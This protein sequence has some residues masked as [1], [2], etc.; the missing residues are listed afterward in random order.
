MALDITG[1]Q[2]RTYAEILN[3]QIANAKNLFGEDIDTSDLTPLGKFIRINTYDLALAEEEME[4]LYYAIFPMTATGISLDRLCVFVG[5]TRNASIKSS[6]TVTISGIAGSEIAQGFLVGTE[7]GVNFAVKEP[8]VI[9]TDGTVSLSV[10]CVESGEIG[11]VLPEEINTIVNPSA[12]ITSV[13]GT[14][15]EIKGEEVESDPELRNRFLDARN[16]MGSCNSAAIRSALLRVPTVTHA[17]VTVNDTDETD[18]DGR[19]PHSFECYVEGGENYHQKIAETIFDKKPVGIKTHG[20][21]SQEITDIGGHKHTIK[22]SHTTRVTV[23][24]RMTIK[25]DSTFLGTKSKE[26][27]KDKLD[28]HISKAGIG[29]SVILSSLYGQIHSVQGVTEVTELLLST[30]GKTWSE[31]NIA[32]AEDES[33]LLME[34]EIKANAETSYE[35]IV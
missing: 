3:D 29:K 26:K 18:S 28:S 13:I 17:G 8:T 30:D 9:G 23:Y 11:N 25:T 16:G 32:T 27:I 6:Y 19:P 34:T 35:V 10:E 15:L 4:L 2:R 20:S 21:V 14:T 7:S 24:V 12:S 22:F 5:I 33:C 31:T 1:F